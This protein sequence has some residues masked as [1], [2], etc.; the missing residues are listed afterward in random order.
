MNINMLIERKLLLKIDVSYSLMGIAIIFLLTI[1][2]E[3]LI[4]FSGLTLFYDKPNLIQIVFHIMGVIAT[5][6]F[7]LHDDHYRNLWKI[8]IFGGYY[9]FI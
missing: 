7:V 2:I 4:M 1:I 9:I 5:S 3:F 6:F 8:W